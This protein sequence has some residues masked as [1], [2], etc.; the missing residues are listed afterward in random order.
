ME[1]AKVTHN[2]DLHIYDSIDLEK[3]HHR[4]RMFF[5]QAPGVPFDLP[6]QYPGPISP[7]SASLYIP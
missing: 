6:L 2:L 5:T 3:I 7:R 4:N 1:K